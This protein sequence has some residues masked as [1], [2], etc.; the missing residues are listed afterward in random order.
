MAAFARETLTAW[1]EADEVDIETSRG[2]D[3]PRHRVTIWIVVDSDEVF[4]RSV[5]GPTGRWYREISANP[6]GAIHLAGTRTAVHAVP[7][8]D[9]ATVARVS[10]LLKAKYGAQSPGPTARMVADETLPTTLRLE[11]NA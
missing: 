2:G 11:P 8:A 1:A 3:A 4:V 9:E 6:N 10:E 5:R 7:A